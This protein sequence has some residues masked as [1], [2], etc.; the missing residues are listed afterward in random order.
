MKA[1]IINL[2]LA[3]LVELETTRSTYISYLCSSLRNQIKQLLLRLNEVLLGLLKQV[4]PIPFLVL[5][6]IFPFEVG[7]HGFLDD[8]VAHAVS[9]AMDES[10]FQH[11][12]VKCNREGM[13][14]CLKRQR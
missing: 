3:A 13:H 9:D 11:L 14:I 7:R 8:C 10:G 5:P 1:L 4:L 6:P 2:C 12:G